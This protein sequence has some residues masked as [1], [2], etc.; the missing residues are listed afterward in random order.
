MLRVTEYAKGTGKP[1]VVFE[2]SEDEV[3]ALLQSAQAKL[4]KKRLQRKKLR[5]KLKNKRK[6]QNSLNAENP[7]NIESKEV[8]TATE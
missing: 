7:T 5:E 6:Q 1:S 4:E 2:A 3:K 8:S